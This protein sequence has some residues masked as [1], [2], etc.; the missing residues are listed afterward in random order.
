MVK[1]CHIADIHIKNLE[2]HDEYRSQFEKLYK[3]IQDN[4]VD[5]VAVVGDLFDRFVEIS[6]EAKI[7]AGEFLNKLSSISKEVIIVSGNHDLM[8]KNLNRISS[9]ETIVK[10]INNSKI[11]YFDKSGFY[12]DKL[13]NITWVNHA[14]QEKNINPWINIP[15]KKDE[16]KIYIDLFHDPVNGCST[17]VGKIFQDSK[18][19]SI[20]D[21]KGDLS[22]L[23]DIHK[24]QALDKNKKIVYSSSLV[25]QDFGESFVH[26]C[27]IW[28]INSKKDIKWIFTNIDNDHAFINLYIN[29][30]TDYDNIN[31]IIPTFLDSEVKIHWKDYSSNITTV[32]ERKI[33]DY[34]KLN[35]NINKIKFEKVFIYND[36]ISS[37]MLSE[38]LD[39][40][41]ITVQN[42][43]FKEYLEEQKYKK[44]DIDEILKI[45][46][47]V[48]NRLHISDKKVNIS[49][50]ID[51]F[52][53]SNF[54]SY[55]DNNEVDWKEI[56]G[57]IQVHGL[58][59]EGKT[60]ILDAITYILYGKTTTTLSPEKNGDN[61]FINNKR[62]LNYCYGG[63]IIDVNGEK[64]TIQRRTDRTWSR[65]GSEIT[66]CST[67]LDFYK[68]ELI[69]DKNKLTGEVKKKT[70]EKLDLILGDLK[71]FIRLS[72]T[73][74]DNL[75][76]TLSETRSIFMDN[77]I[78]DAGYDIF[79]TK[80]EEFKEYKKELGE[81]KLVVDIQSSEDLVFNL[82]SEI[83]S[84]NDNI[85]INKVI[86]ENFEKELKNHNVNRDESNK[87]L[88]NIDSSMINFDENL[89]LQS[90]TNYNK[91]IEESNFQ[92]KIMNRDIES[93]PLEFKTEKINNLKIKLKD[94]ND[95][96]SERK[97]EISKIR[98]LITESDNKKDKVLSKIKEL[99]D[100]EIK[101]LLLSNS[102]NDLKIGIIKNQKENIVN[103]EIRIIK[104]DIQKIELEKNNI[105]NKMK[106]LQRDGTNLKNANDEI[107]MDIDD[108]NNS[109][110]CPTCGRDYEEGSIHL[111]HLK[112]S[113][114]KLVVKKDDNTTKIQVFLNDYK[115]LKNQLPELETKENILKSNKDNLKQCIYSDDLKIKLKTVGSIKQ[116][117][118]D[119]IKIK[120]KIEEIKNNIFDNV[121]T[122][123]E[124]IA[125]GNIIL[126][127][128]ENSKN[129][130]LQVIKN[131]ESELKSFD[132]ENIESDIDIEE[133]QRTNFEL[134][135]QKIS[136][137]DNLLLSIEN[138]NLR[139]KDL[140]LEL[141]KYE[142][143]KTKIEENKEIQFS[144]DR[145]DEMILIV[146]E[147]I[148][149]LTDENIE[150][151]K[152]ILIKEKEIETIE[153]K[154]VKYLKQKKKDE[155]L[156]EYQKCISRDGL[157]FFLLKKSI[158]L[159]NKELS[160][161]LTNVDFTLF[162]DENLV[163]KMSADDRLDVNQNAVE[164]SGKERVFCS[165]A[166]K[167]ALRQINVKS[168]SNFIFCDELTGKLIGES[169]QQFM[170]FLDDL[171]NKV[172][173]IIII[174]HTH[175]VNYD[176]IITVKKDVNLISSLSI[177]S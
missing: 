132:I 98:H 15:H 164:S 145:I 109:T 92:I 166:L 151:E 74:A 2:R 96:I 26:G 71:D 167:I 154:I 81:E 142:E 24:H 7:L 146:K 152:E 174:E 119:N 27:V 69:D 165:L 16:S 143:Y 60:T 168:K 148:K 150:T 55:G 59:Q 12:D 64:F 46:E 82:N 133:K 173:K 18:L 4:D 68:D 93:L 87:K 22:L 175:S 20:S 118:D 50:S 65:N 19:R 54:K 172:N 58:N 108:L 88:N 9:I 11:T 77:I 10:L 41:D 21:F 110:S 155:L 160:E 156:K 17:D 169:V 13:F 126:K 48:N 111:N 1:I 49:W 42:T 137:K 107:D 163:L 95:K 83:K 76:D 62:N 34:I 139:I 36:V 114:D 72:F 90:I 102:D 63:A 30:S 23:G 129:D 141:G 45:D 73:N 144:I 130:N 94:T 70:Q 75:N 101:K 104:D 170:D 8:K 5:I 99:K 106:L 31:L 28:N 159:I 117:R 131:I 116:L 39:L 29:E 38:S 53:F 37:K 14:H 157:P 79:E 128:V 124:N 149:E 100:T 66:K 47:I 35:F 56:D 44:D 89:N 78:R 84:S 57:I 162:F 113:I 123:S 112:Q 138:F 3:I 40:T 136:Q 135:K 97:D 176:Q 52:W 86:I 140:Q 43:I 67:T 51:K 158:H 85:K 103:Q 80:L 127:N 153:N 32:N 171:K 121:I 122:L 91:K 33:R 161:L 6:N 134:R 125:K 115:K 61:R 177:D 105:S 25:Q 120:E 147:N